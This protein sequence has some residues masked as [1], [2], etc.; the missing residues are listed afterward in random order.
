MGVTVCLCAVG[1]AAGVGVSNCGWAVMVAGIVAES[2]VGAA[3]VAGPA[4]GPWLAG[5]AGC[6]LQPDMTRAKNAVI[7]R[8]FAILRGSEFIVAS[9]QLMTS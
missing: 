1:V 9:W 6:E 2:V 3:E 4:G 7:E 5:V 8:S